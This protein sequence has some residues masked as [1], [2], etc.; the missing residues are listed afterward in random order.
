[1][2]GAEAEHPQRGEEAGCGAELGAKGG[3]GRGTFKTQGYL[4]F[5]YFFSIAVTLTCWCALNMHKH[6]MW[7][8]LILWKPYRYNVWVSWCG[9]ETTRVNPKMETP[10]WSWRW[11]SRKRSRKQVWPG[12]PS[13]LCSSSCR[14]PES[15]A[16]PGLPTTTVPAETSTFALYEFPALPKNC[17]AHSAYSKQLSLDNLAIFIDAER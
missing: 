13:H 17:K 12:E 1:M 2:K 9:I 16:S 3:K 5:S 6:I 11:N 8:G 14:W 7:M 4:I 10:R 15:H